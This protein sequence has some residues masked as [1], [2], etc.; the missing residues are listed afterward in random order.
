[1]ATYHLVT[2]WHIE[3]PLSAAFD[4]I[5][6]SLHWPEWWPGCESVEQLEAGDATGIGS[7]RRYVWRS[8]LPY[9]LCF[10]ARA[11]R[12]EPLLALEA[13]TSGDLEGTGRWSFWEEDG[14]IT[15][16]YDWHVRT[17]KRWMNLVAPVARVVFDRNH[18][19]LMQRGAEGLAR[20]LDARL[21]AATSQRERPATILQTRLLREP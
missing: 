1:M 11:T 15:V 16:R 6:D 10:D 13:N 3:A 8:W 20:R 12:F 21:I 19:A 17:T 7:V 4:T 9:R 14:V 18:H 5:L 2:H